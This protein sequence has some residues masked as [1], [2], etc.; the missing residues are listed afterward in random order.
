MVN[1]IFQWYLHGDRGPGAWLYGVAAR[2]NEQGVLI[3]GRQWTKGRI[4]D[5]LT[6]EPISREALLSSINTK[7]RGRDVRRMKP[8]EEWVPVKVDPL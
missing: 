7:S 8:R 6:N 1:R 5:V 3:R 2:L 4:Y